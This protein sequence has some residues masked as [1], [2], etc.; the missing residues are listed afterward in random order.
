MGD[1]NIGT[2]G[3]YS[4]HWYQVLDTPPIDLPNSTSTLT[5]SFDQKRAIE[6]LCSGTNFPECTGGVI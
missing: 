2:N 5:V 6:N 4:D 3:G 1:P